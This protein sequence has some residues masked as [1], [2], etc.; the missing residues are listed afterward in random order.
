[1]V[2]FGYI[3]DQFGRKT[4]A[5]ATTVLLTIGIIMSTASNGL[6]QTGMLWMLVIARGVAGVGAGGEY[7]VTG[8][9]K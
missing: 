4:G 9:L 1:M 6:T 2:F 5:I 3:A 8:E 7:P